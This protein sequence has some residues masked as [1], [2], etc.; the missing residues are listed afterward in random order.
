MKLGRRV[1]ILGALAVALAAATG[2]TTAG[3]ARSAAE[4]AKPRLI[5]F[6]TCGQL[7]GYAKGQMQRFVGPYG[8][9]SLPPGVVETA[10]PSPAARA[11]TPVQ[12]V[13]FSGTNVQEEGVDEPDLV[14]TNGKTL[15]AVA[16]GSL[17]A[18]D[19][20]GLRP[21]LLDS[22]PLDGRSATSCCSTA[23]GCSCSRAAATGSSRCPPPPPGS[24]RTS[25]QSPCWPRWTCPIPPGCGSCAR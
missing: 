21:R 6:G 14:K 9:G 7:L 24:P 18:V 8:Y 20:S 13:D 3:T 15:F 1:A 19:V 22:L 5:A 12:G 2:G 10:V 23:T 4:A 25:R 16:N 17:R 11:A